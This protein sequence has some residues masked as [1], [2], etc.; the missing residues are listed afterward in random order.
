[1]PITLPVVSIKAIDNVTE[2]GAQLKGEI[3][4]NGNGTILEKGF[5]L[6]TDAQTPPAVGGTGV[7][8]FSNEINSSGEYTIDAVGLTGGGTYYIRAFA[9]N[10]A[11]TAYSTVSTFITPLNY[12]AEFSITS[13]NTSTPIDGANITIDGQTLSAPM[14]YTTDASGKAVI[15]L[16]DGVYSYTV[17]KTGHIDSLGVFTVDSA[18]IKENVSLEASYTIRFIVTDEKG[19]GVSGYNLWFN[20]P[21]LTL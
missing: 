5:V 6:N 10:G 17:S 18:D 14:T 21:E 7:I 20:N 1:M 16:A 4:N 13:K 2:T 12:N 11:G 15:R 3:T 9:K 8:K 19:N